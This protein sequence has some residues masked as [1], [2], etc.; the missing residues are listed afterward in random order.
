MIKPTTFDGYTPE[1]LEVVRSTCLTIA[2][3]LGD[4]MDD[5]VIVGGLVPSFLLP[6][7]SAPDDPYGSHVSTA[8]VDIALSLTLLDEKRY[9]KVSERLRRAGFEQD[10]NEDGNRTRHRWRIT[11]GEHMGLVEFL[12][13][14]V[15]VGQAGQIQSLE[16]DIG[17]IAMTGIHLAFKD[18]ESVILKGKTLDGDT[19]KRM[20]RVCGPGAFVVLK[21]LA[22]KGRSENK[23]AY[24][25]FIVLRS[26]GKGPSSVAIRLAPLRDEPDV[27][28]ALAILESNF[29]RPTDVGPSRMA[30][31][32]KREDDQG[33]RQD[34]VGYVQQFLRAMRS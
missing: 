4:L 1:M 5:I 11:R 8:D 14:P 3:V 15:K 31:F 34:V 16:R 19:A 26:Y 6:T 18:V 10:E 32:L 24:D 7:E 33:L 20:V 29:A 28:E 2:T 27:I 21:A 23:D 30:R 9:K 17:A 22:I 25:L 12:I 13:Q